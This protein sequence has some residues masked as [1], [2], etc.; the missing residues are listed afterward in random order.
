MNRKR[1]EDKRTRKEMRKKDKKRKVE[2]RT[3]VSVE[4]EF[5]RVF[6]PSS[7]FYKAKGK[8]K[9]VKDVRK[10]ED[11]AVYRILAG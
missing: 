9:V 5:K 7:S 3:A 6:R 8:R 2:E 4:E 1:D 11:C 10:V